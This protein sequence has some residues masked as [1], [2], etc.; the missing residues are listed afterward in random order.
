MNYSRRSLLGC[1]I[2]LQQHPR[3]TD[4]VGVPRTD[5]VW[6]SLYES[7]EAFDHLAYLSHWWSLGFLLVLD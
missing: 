2:D 5:E 3:T 4:T 7:V 6:S 1:R